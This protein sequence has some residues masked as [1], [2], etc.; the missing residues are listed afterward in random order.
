MWSKESVELILNLLSEGKSYKEVSEITGKTE[1]SIRNKAYK[2]GVKS[3]MFYKPK[4]VK[5]L[6]VECG[7]QFEDLLSRNRTF[8]S[9]SCNAKFNNKK[10]GYKEKTKSNCIN[11][12]KEVTGKKYCGV[13]CQKVYERNNVFEKIEN[14]DTSLHEKNY[15][16]YLI[17][18]YGEKCMKCDWCERHTITNKVPIQLEHIDG[19]SGNNCL[20]NLKLLCP[21]CHSL[22]PTYG[23]LNKGNGRKNRKR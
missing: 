15:K 18:K 8:C 23:A 17:Y 3:S 1:G 5:S 11:C 14:G 22:T 9:Q 4:S 12:D 10:R 6:C 20:D 2:Y 16:N 21:N 7:N 19:N 13:I